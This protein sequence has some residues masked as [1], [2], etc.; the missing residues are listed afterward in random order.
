MNNHSTDGISFLPKED[1]KNI[2]G[3]KNL[4]LYSFGLPQYTAIFFNQKQ[5]DL[6]KDKNIR[7]ALQLAI[8]RPEIL[9][10]ALQL[11]GTIIDGPILLSE[12][13]NQQT[14][15]NFDSAKSLSLLLDDKWQ[16][17]TP[18]DYQQFLTEQKQKVQTNQT[19]TN[20]NSNQSTASTT[21]IVDQPLE[22]I[23]QTQEFYL[24]K[25]DQ[26]LEIDLTT[27]NQS[28]NSIAANLVKQAWEKIGVKVNLKIVEPNKISR[29]IIKPRNY[30]ALLYGIIVGSNP[31]PYPFWHSSQIQDP[32]LNLT[33]LANRN[34]DKLLED[35]RASSDDK[36]KQQNYL[37]FQKIITEEIPAIFLYNPTYTYV[38]DKKIKGIDIE[39]IIMPADRFNN[40]DSWYTKTKRIYRPN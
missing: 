16:K 23:D 2:V 29:E 40:I 22:L 27:V 21:P 18:L 24:K 14:T 12:T 19:K 20:Q 37:A 36:I 26:I 10:E 11:E 15:N 5:N 13:N 32:G 35:A 30:Q 28:E 3:Q 33:G 38:V 25:A 8:N 4:Q 7:T 17:I 34:A 39:R 1:K 31:D 6:L 9:S